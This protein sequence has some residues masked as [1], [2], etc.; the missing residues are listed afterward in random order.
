MTPRNTVISK[1][2]SFH[3]NGSVTYVCCWFQKFR[4]YVCRRHV[5]RVATIRRTERQVTVCKTMITQLTE[6]ESGVHKG[7]IRL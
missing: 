5:L 1:V 4:P 6:E 2:L 7:I 3:Y